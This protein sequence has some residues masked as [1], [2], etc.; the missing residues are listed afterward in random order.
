[1][2]YKNVESNTEHKLMQIFSHICGNVWDSRFQCWAQ[3]GLGLVSSVIERA[4]GVQPL[5]AICAYNPRQTII[6]FDLK[7][8]FN[9]LKCIQMNRE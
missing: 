5:I 2:V 9:L 6:F 7:F 4:P 3:L 8:N 1:M